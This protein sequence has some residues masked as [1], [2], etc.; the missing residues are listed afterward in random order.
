[1]PRAVEATPSAD[2]CSY[3]ICSAQDEVSRYNAVQEHRFRTKNRRGPSSEAVQDRGEAWQTF[4]EKLVQDQVE[5]LDMVKRRKEARS[6]FEEQQKAKLASS[7]GSN[8]KGLPP[9]PPPG[10]PPSR[11]QGLAPSANGSASAAATTSPVPKFDALTVAEMNERNRRA[12]KERLIE[13]EVG[14]AL[15]VLADLQS[16]AH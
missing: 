7:N 10:P 6:A 3:R 5:A 16:I 12:E 11:P 14:L 15:V 2:R 1:M 8:G 4:E 9:G 13:V